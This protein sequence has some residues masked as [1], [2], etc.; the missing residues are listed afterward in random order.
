[1]SSNLLELV[2]RRKELR[3]AVLRAIVEDDQ[4]M[5][6]SAWQAVDNAAIA[7]AREHRRYKRFVRDV[8]R[9][10]VPVAA[11]EPVPHGVVDD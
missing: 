1:M 2:S 8:L 9:N 6:V 11:A 4:A 5:Q 3:D 7:L 10:R